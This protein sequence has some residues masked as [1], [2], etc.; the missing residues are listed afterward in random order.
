M[1]VNRFVKVLC[2]PLVMLVTLSAQ[3][4]VI[5][6]EDNSDPTN[7]RL[8]Q[9][10]AGI[11]FFGTPHRGSDTAK[12]GNL[13]GTMINTFLKAASAG[14]QTKTIRTD[15]LRH[16]ES[17]SKALQELADSVRDR[18]GSL[19]IVSFYET[20]PESSWPSVSHIEVSL[21]QITPLGTNL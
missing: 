21:A 6:H 11:V 2:I 8:L 16:L 7:Q 1:F 13:V 20:E 10:M 5:A 14:L 12:L 3:A 9:S 18:L 15:L 17:D 19:Q 4:L